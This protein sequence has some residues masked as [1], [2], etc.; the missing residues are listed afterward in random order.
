MHFIL[1][2]VFRRRT[3]MCRRIRYINLLECFVLYRDRV[4]ASLRGGLGARARGRGRGRSVRRRA[5]TGPVPARRVP[6]RTSSPAISC[7]EPK[8]NVT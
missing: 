3:R 2:C 5:A 6:A 7:N 1:H 8:L 4:V